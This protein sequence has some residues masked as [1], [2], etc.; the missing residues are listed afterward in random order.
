[1]NVC[2]HICIYACMYM[3]ETISGDEIGHGV[4]EQGGTLEGNTCIVNRPN[5]TNLV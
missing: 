1:M 2:M 3:Y 4:I 5:I